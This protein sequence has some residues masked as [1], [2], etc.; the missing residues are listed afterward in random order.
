MRLLSWNINGIRAAHRKGFVNWLQRAQPD[1]LALQ[2]VRALPDQVPKDIRTAENYH[3]FWFPAEK[4]GYSGVGLMSK[5]RPQAVRYGL[6]QPEFDNEGRVI[7]AEYKAFTLFNG[8]FPSGTSG[9]ERIDYKLAFNEA[10]LSAIEDVRATGKPVV[11]CGDVNIAH[12]PID[13][14]N[15]KA[16]AKNSGFLPIEREWLDRLMDFGYIDTFRHF[17][18]DTPEMYSWWTMRNNARERNIG[19][20]IDYFIVSDAL[21][22]AL[23]DAQILTSVTGSDHCPVALELD[24][25]AIQKTESQ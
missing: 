3:T 9:Q 4:R 25:A 20:R 1:V 13:L 6:G 17:Y 2:E 18:P 21:R 7:I 15:P 23:K 14:T 8:Y 16:N 5:I 22:P 24:L 19:W 12:Q 10:F 11:V